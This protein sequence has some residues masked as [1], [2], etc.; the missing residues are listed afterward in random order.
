[1]WT[2][3]VIHRVRWRERLHVASAAPVFGHMKDDIRDLK[4]G[5]ISIRE[6]LAGMRRDGLRQGAHHCS[7]CRWTLSASIS[8]SASKTPTH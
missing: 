6:D 3:L 7:P 4:E 5:Q 1:M 8:G 2:S